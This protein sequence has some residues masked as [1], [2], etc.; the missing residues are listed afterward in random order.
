M[1]TYVFGDIQGCFDELQNLLQEINFNKS[2]DKLIFAGDIIN[3]GPKSL[4]T[5]EYIISLGSSAEIVLGNHELLFLAISYGYKKANTSKLENILQSKNLSNIQEWLSNQKMLI[6]ID[7]YFITHAG[8]PHTW[9]K[10]K[11][12][13]RAKELENIL[14]NKETRAIFLQNLFYKKPSLWKKRITKTQRWI[15]T[16]NY[17]TRMRI[18][19]KYGQLNL[20]Y[21]STLEN[22]PKNYKAWFDFENKHFKKSTIL[23]GHWAA[24]DGKTHKTNYIALDTGC[25]FGGKLTCF[26]LEK[27]KYYS[28]E[29]QKYKEI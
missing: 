1:A 2:K 8:I 11:T 24:L 20:K 27:S 9:S 6:N 13:F 12:K 15:S 18:V 25:V 29:S 5:I 28:V 14:S 21:S 4:E 22:V 19:D 23:F 10:K 26:C 3:K 7:K 16:A 17:L